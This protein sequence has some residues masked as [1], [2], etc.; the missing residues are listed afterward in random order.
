M[1]DEKKIKS[2]LHAK[3]L[4][5]LDTQDLLDVQQYID[6]GLN[7]PWAELGKFQTI[8]SMFPLILDLEIPNPKLK[9]NV[10]LRLKKLSEELRLKKKDEE[11]AVEEIG[12]NGQQAEAVS[13][14]IKE[15]ESGSETKIQEGSN[16]NEINLPEMEQSASLTGTSDEDVRKDNLPKVTAAKEAF[17]VENKIKDYIE[18]NAEQIN[19]V[20][21]VVGGVKQIDVHKKSLTEKIQKAL[22]Q[23]IDLLKFNLEESE[24]KLTKGLF[25][26]YIIIAVLLALLIFSFFKFSADIKSLENE[27]KQLKKQ[28]S[29]GLLILN[30]DVRV[31]IA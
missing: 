23:D 24:K 20:E 21:D 10:A 5:C 13:E 9:D 6:E 4:G 22:E 27:I 16:L 1:I 11:A 14:I 31:D 26:V 2:M 7:F 15:K 17:P 3:A 18:E 25:T 28:N 8:A 12:I 19:L 29:S 30:K